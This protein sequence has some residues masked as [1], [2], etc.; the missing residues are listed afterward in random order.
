MRL[1]TPVAICIGVL[2]FV[3]AYHFNGVYFRALHD[4]ISHFLHGY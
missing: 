3:D 4:I 2:Y 1:F